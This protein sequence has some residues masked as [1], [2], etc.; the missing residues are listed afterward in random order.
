[1]PPGERGDSAAAWTAGQTDLQA[2]LDKRGNA[3]DATQSS[4]AGVIGT[5]AKSAPVGKSS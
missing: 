4:R 3:T 2:G 1:M 5:R